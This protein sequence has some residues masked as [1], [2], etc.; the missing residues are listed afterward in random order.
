MKKETLYSALVGFLGFF[1]L[2]IVGIHNLF[3]KMII[4]IIGIT[5]T[6]MYLEKKKKAL[7]DDEEQK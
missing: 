1:L 6:V 3:V 2:D 7:E 5:L 4:V